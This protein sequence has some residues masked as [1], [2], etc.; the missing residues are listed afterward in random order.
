MNSSFAQVKKKF[1][2]IWQT[3]SQNIFQ[4]KKNA[5][6]RKYF[7]VQMSQTVEDKIFKGI[8]K[9]IFRSSFVLNAF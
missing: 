7:P 2:K 6:E 5:L 4:I 9:S 3:Y 1:W 8:I